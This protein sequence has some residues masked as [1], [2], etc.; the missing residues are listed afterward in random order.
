[1]RLAGQIWREQ[2]DVFIRPA[3]IEIIACHTPSSRTPTGSKGMSEGSVIGALGAVTLA[4][5]DTLAPLRVVVE[6]QPFIAGNIRALLKA[7]PATMQAL[8]LT[9]RS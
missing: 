1:V 2:A 3:P 8:R 4:V 5:N 6:R 9:V 7:T